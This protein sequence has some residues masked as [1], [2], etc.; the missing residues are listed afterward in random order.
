MTLVRDPLREF[1][2]DLASA[3]DKRGHVHG[4]HPYPAKFIPHIP[5]QLV[6]H[7]TQPGDVVLDPM[8][9]SGTT[10]VE[11]SLQERSSIGTDINPVA[12]LASQ[13]KTSRLTSGDLIALDRL[14][15]RLTRFLSA[16]APRVR[17]V[18]RDFPN[19]DHWFDFGVA[20]DIEQVLRWIDSIAET[21]ARTTAKCALSAI[22]VLASRQ[23][24]ETRWAAKP[25]AHPPNFVQ[26]RFLA[27][28][29]DI[30]ERQIRYAASNPTSAQVL[31]ADARA[32]PLRDDIID[33]V[34]TSPPYANSHD[35]YLYNKLRMFWLGEDVLDVQEREFG[36]RNKHSDKKYDIDHYVT[37]MRA[38][39]D[40]CA[41][42]LR[43]DGVAALVVAD[44]VIRGE[45][46][47]MR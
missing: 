37:S 18:P 24:S 42:V 1:F 25:V 7:L 5:R 20:S 6:Q 34:I 46:F 9:G 39:L 16:P 14:E 27:K 29:R 38:V 23:E 32:L 26:G 19:R 44:S 33:A 28:L 2:A 47:D 41:R 35:Y 8:C 3:T 10:L 22:I 11:A 40:E 15:G 31:R 36:S 21:G 13:A 45:F 17:V 30:R 4:A 43:P 12:L